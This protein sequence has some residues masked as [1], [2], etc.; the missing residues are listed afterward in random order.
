MNDPAGWPGVKLASEGLAFCVQT[1][2]ASPPDHALDITSLVAP[3]I[4]IAA[5]PLQLAMAEPAVADGKP[6]TAT[7]TLVQVELL[8]VVPQEA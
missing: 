1:P 6:L 2:N 5:V 8:H 4:A 3:V 7:V